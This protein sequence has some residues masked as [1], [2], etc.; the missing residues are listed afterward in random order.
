MKKSSLGETSR[1][2]E[3]TAKSGCTQT[4]GLRTEPWDTPT[5][6]WG[7]EKEQPVRQEEIQGIREP[8]I[9]EARC[10]KEESNR[11]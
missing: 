8:G 1:L 9:L 7:K 6:A 4:R 11:L 5:L 3:M 10:I 2:E